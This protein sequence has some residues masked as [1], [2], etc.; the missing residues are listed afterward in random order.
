MTGE[1]GGTCKGD[2]LVRR[3]LVGCNMRSRLRES[4]ESY[5]AV[6][7]SEDWKS[8]VG[9]YL[10]TYQDISRFGMVKQYSVGRPIIGKVLKTRI[11]VV[12]PACLGSR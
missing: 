12:S 10:L 3:S 5:G 8:T 1:L 9:L 7:D 4:F 6:L 11:C 2:S